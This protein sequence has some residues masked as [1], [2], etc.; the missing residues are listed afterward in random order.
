MPANYYK[1]S[2]NMNDRNYFT[3]VVTNTSGMDKRY[4]SNI[5]SEI[6]F[7]DK[8]M[9]DLY[10]FEFSIDEKIL[11]IYG[12]NCYYASELV[13]GQR[14]VQGQFVVNYTDTM[15]IQNTLQ[16]IDYS[17]YNQIYSDD[18][19]PGGDMHNAIYNKAFD[20]MIGYGYY[21]LKDKQTYNA[22]C[23]TILGA[24]ISGMHKVLDTT[25]QPILEVFTFVAKDFIEENITQSTTGN[26]VNTPNNNN[27]NSASPVLSYVCSD[28]Y[29]KNEISKN[30]SYV[31][32]NAN[33]IN[34]IHNLV[35]KSGMI[36]V[37]V[38][39]GTNEDIT[40]LSGSIEITDKLD[41]TITLPVFDFSSISKSV[42][43]IKL[44]AKYSS[45]INNY[46]KNGASKINCTLRYKV[47][48][49]DSN[50]LKKEFNIVYEDACIHV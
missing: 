1:Y 28:A 45:L 13:S 23:Q 40:L 37:Q 42:G 36:T 50:G 18:Y 27:Q 2:A 12:Y 24:K 4:F 38:Q 33:C 9:T 3:S 47:R 17:I 39:S 31:E 10:Q 25:G 6:Y 22:T 49:I 48:I 26:N 30:N 32:K 5:E 7:G 8:E 43:T 16:D 41:K 21:D 11:P 14:I 29:D 19:V 46:T 34:F 20:I 35:Y 15:L 44:D